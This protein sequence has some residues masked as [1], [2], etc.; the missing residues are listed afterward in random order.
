M[1]RARQ[2]VVRIERTNGIKP[3]K[4]AGTT[5]MIASFEV[6]SALERELA[7]NVHILHF[8]KFCARPGSGL[9]YHSES[10]WVHGGLWKKLSLFG[11][12]C[13]NEKG[14]SLEWQIMEGTATTRIEMETILRTKERG[15]VL[16]E[17]LRVILSKRRIP[18]LTF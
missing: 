6:E 13:E 17:R 5:E 14:R 15:R 12:P 4:T 8:V 18:A 16:Q 7:S 10:Y 1:I 3:T 9:E 2:S 11:E